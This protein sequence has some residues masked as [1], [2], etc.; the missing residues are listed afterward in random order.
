EKITGIGIQY[1]MY[2]SIPVIT[3]IKSGLSA[4]KAGIQ[5]GD[6]I[7]AING[8]AVIGKSGEEI[9]V[10]LKGESGSE[11][12]LKILTIGG[13]EK[14]LSVMRMEFHETNVPYFGMLNK[15]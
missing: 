8:K 15:H 3:E 14:T 9:G 1:A 11:V 2:D 5:V 6:K 13:E 4:E 12:Q 7:L 10:A